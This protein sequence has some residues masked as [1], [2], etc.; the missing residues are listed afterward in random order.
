MS[1]EKSKALIHSLYEAFNKRNLDALD[2]LIAPDYVDYSRQER[3]L[4]SVKQYYIDIYKGLT[5]TK[6]SPISI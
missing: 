2:D 3:G 1:L 5:F 6:A 4:E